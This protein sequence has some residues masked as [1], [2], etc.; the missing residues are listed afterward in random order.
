MEP[1]ISLIT[2][3]VG[4]LTGSLKFYRDGLGLPLEGDEA[5]ALERGI[6]FF[7]LN[8]YLRLGLFPWDDLA[9]DAKTG[10]EG[11][12]FRGIS[13]AHNVRSRDEVDAVIDRAVAAGATLKK[14]A[15][16]VSWG[17]YSGY[18][19]DPDGHLWEVAYNPYDEIVTDNAP[20]DPKRPDCIVYFSEIQ[21]DDDAHYPG[22]DELLS[23]GSNFG[24]HFDFDRLGIHHELLL[25]GRRT[26]WPHAESREDEFVFVI[27]GRPQVW[28][29]GNVYDLRPGDAAG[30]PAGTGQA[31]TFI[32]NTDQD[33][34]LMVVGDTSHRDNRC[35]YPLNPKRNAAIGDFLWEDAPERDLGPHDGRPDALREE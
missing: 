34:R 24:R 25:P 28:L 12:G 33:V 13:L 6:A 19:E 23:I 31:H 20:A 16:A 29:D 9:D 30:F 32:N 4:D 26:S 3:G 7:R 27:E 1:R 10:A 11:S 21:H 2:L 14:A 22:S 15:E 18:F 35:I 17:G 5:K 8:P